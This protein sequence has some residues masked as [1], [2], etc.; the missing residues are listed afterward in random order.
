M[1]EWVWLKQVSLLKWEKKKNSW[2][3]LVRCNTTLVDSNRWCMRLGMDQGQVFIH[4]FSAYDIYD[5]VK[6][7]TSKLLFRLTHN[8]WTAWRVLIV[9]KLKK[10]SPAKVSQADSST[11]LKK[12]LVDHTKHIFIPLFVCAKLTPNCQ[13][14]QEKCMKLSPVV[15]GFYGSLCEASST[16]F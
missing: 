13:Y 3:T 15:H 1:W 7:H 9:H 11:S 8:N 5:T 4:L 12:N 2:V 14:M 10:G 6:S 16:S